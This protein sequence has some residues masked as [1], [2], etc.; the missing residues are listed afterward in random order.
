MVNA[1][2]STMPNK[3]Q[4][5]GHHRSKLSL[6]RILSYRFF[7]FFMRFLSIRSTHIYAYSVVKERR[8]FA[9]R[10]RW[11]NVGVHKITEDTRSSKSKLFK[12]FC[13]FMACVGRFLVGLIQAIIATA[14]C[15]YFWPQIFEFLDHLLNL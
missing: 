1:D 11:F 4:N 2:P 10:H 5:I 13:A 9:E 15:M 7:N 8:G 14:L 12:R 3:R 6:S